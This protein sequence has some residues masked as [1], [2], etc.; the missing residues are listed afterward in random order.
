MD[1][2]PTVKLLACSLA[3][4]QLLEGSW[5]L[6]LLL[7]SCFTDAAIDVRPPSC[8]ASLHWQAHGVMGVGVPPLVMARLV[9]PPLPRIV[10]VSQW[11]SCD[12]RLLF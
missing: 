6:L 7:C 10:T 9:T 5:Q 3:S 11:P 4:R 1:A 12:P 8:A 2:S